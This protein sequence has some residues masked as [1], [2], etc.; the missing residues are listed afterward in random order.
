M[1]IERTFSSRSRRERRPVRS[2]RR[3]SSRLRPREVAQQPTDEPF[4]SRR[5]ADRRPGQ[6]VVERRRRIARPFFHVELRERPLGD[7]KGGRRRSRRRSI[8][9]ARSICRPELSVLSVAKRRLSSSIVAAGRSTAAK[10]SSQA[11]LPLFRWPP[12]LRSN[13][14][15]KGFARARNLL[16]KA[17]RGL[18]S[19]DSR[20]LQT[21]DVGLTQSARRRR[22]ETPTLGRGSEARIDFLQ[23][24][25]ALIFH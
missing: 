11:A 5:D 25:A 19:H 21:R 10:F 8:S 12:S 14:M 3:L 7:G 1:T 18:S 13:R 16:P 20:T 24:S 22:R 4:A 23:G 17:L 2:T 9:S 15:P 6:E